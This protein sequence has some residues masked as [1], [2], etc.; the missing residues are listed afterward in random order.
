MICFVALIVFALMAL[1]SVR[2]RPLAKEALDCVI[3]KTTFRKCNTNL[4]KRI[5]Y[6]L[7]GRLI[8]KNKALAKFVYGNF[9]ISFIEKVGK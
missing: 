8:T 7:T 4:D 2:Y 1:F 5:K 9:I 3:R 6:Q